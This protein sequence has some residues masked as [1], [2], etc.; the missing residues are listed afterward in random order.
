MNV[1]GFFKE[2]SF[3]MLNHKVYFNENTNKWIVLVHGIGGSMLT[4][5]KQIE[6]FSEKYNLLVLDLPGHGDSQNDTNITIAAVNSKIK[7]VLD[8]EGIVKAD[9]VG[10]SLGSLVVAHFAIK[11]P[12]YVHSIVFGG[13]TLN[14]EGVYRGLLKMVNVIKGILPHRFLYKTFAV[15]LLPNKNHLKSRKIFIRESV[16]LKRQVFLDWIDYLSEILDPQYLIEKLKQLNIKMVFISGDEDYCFIDGTRKVCE[17]LEKFKLLTIEK[18]GH[19]CTIEKYQEF[20]QLA[21]S[22]L[23]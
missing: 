7:E 12:R 11:Y 9:F 6:P 2:V 4:W 10:L 21:L 8:A 20:N 1:L 13:A 3:E 15:V 5:K 14:V 17:K 16:K 18:C 22:F 23:Q 19:V